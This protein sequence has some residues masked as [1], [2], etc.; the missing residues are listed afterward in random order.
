MANL[1][2]DF[3]REQF[4][5]FSDAKS[6]GW[7]HLE[8][9]GGSY[10]PKQVI[11]L[12][13]DFFTTSKVQPYWDFGPSV[14]AGESMDRALELLPVTFNAERDEVHF[15]PST[16]QNTYV[17]AQSLRPKW[18]TGDEIIVT[19]QDHE[20]NV[21]AWRRLETSG[22]T[23]KEWQVDP[24]TGLLEMGHL[25]KLVTG[26]TRLL[27]VTHA[28]NLAAT[29]N[30]IRELTNLIHD[31]GGIVVTDGVSYAPHAAIDV[32]Q[33]DCD[34]YL[35]STYKT[36]G[37]H[38]GLMYTSPRVLSAV[39]H[40]GHFFNSDKPTYRLT[41]A[42]PDHAAIAA[43]AGIMDYYEAIYSHHFGGSDPSSLRERICRV[44]ELFGEHEQTIMTPLVEYVASR[45]DFRLIG[46]PSTDRTVRAPTIAFHSH[47]RPSREIYSSLINAGV[48]CGHGNF[49][50]HRLVEAL[51]LDTDDGVVRLSLVH[52]NTAEEVAKALNVL[53]GIAP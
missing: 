20:A 17:L 24:G 28:S 11:S 8:N 31:V 25:E 23:V 41:P 21:G 47:S 48:S 10:V 3:V 5:V 40:Q 32:K 42:G 27:A 49:Y 6:A 36:Y 16:S 52:Y 37:P 45:A 44:F 18:E 29:I 19:N 53:D 46:S 50:A 9:A 51:G 15:G 13:N 38:V 4:P 30:P 2:L 33:L 7:A 12:L 1:D 22:I 14:K 43:C 34:I 39:S 35:Y 26:R